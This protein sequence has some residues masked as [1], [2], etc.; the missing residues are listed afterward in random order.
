MKTSIAA[1]VLALAASASAQESVEAL[2]A[3]TVAPAPEATPV[4][5]E[6]APAPVVEQ[7]AAPAPEPIVAEA[8]PVEPALEPAATPAPAEEPALPSFG[9]V[10]YGTT[11]QRTTGAAQVVGKKQLERMKYD[12]PHAV[13]NGVAGIVTRGEDGVGLRPN[14]GMRGTNPDRSKKVTLLEDG[15]PF[16][17]AP[18]SA[19]A[20]YYFPLIGRMSQVRVLKGPAGLVYGP[21]TIGGAID[22]V[23]RAIPDKAS[24]GLDLGAGQFGFGKGH[25]WAGTTVDKLGVLVEGMHLRSDGFKQ[26]PNDANTGFIRNEWMAK[27]SYRVAPAHE[28]RLKLTYSD[29]VSNETYLGLTDADLQATPDLRYAATA[30]DQMRNHRTALVFTHVFTPREGLTLTTTIDRSAFDRTWRK[31]NGFRGASLF[32]VLRDPNDPRH[33]VYMN[34]LRG[35]GTSS[36][37]GETLLVGPNVRDFVL[38]GLQTRLHWDPFTGPVEHKVEAGLRLHYDAIERRHSE[39]GFILEAGE[40]IPEGSPT[41]VTAFNRAGTGA[42][43]AHVMDS[44]TWKKLTVTG[45][46]RVETMR[47]SYVDRIT[48][49]ETSRW[50]NAVLPSI[51]AFYGFTESFGVLGGVFQGFSP[52]APGSDAT[53]EPERSTNYELGARFTRKKAGIEIIGYY[54]DYANL[55]DICTLSSGCVDQDLD[56]QFDAGEARIYGVEATAREEFSLG[57]LRFPVSLAYTLTRANFSTA[58]DSDDPMYGKVAAGDELPYVPRHQ[59]NATVGIE[60]RRASLNVSGLYVSR[61]REISGSVPMDA[62]LATDAQFVVDASGSVKLREWLS[63]YTNVRNIADARYIVSRR[64]F[65]ARPN[66]PRW[67]QFGLKA[68]F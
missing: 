63:L 46:V 35:T 8:P 21:Q 54:N 50:A 14:I 12:D 19:P 29:E 39:D 52:P 48:N 9:A 44:A 37:P 6:A 45:G 3:A 34:L 58:F 43:A 26:L 62:T 57:R 67:V 16:A 24:A 36:S 23:T 22:F 2:P 15:V 20:A 13:L 47:S 40:L 65:G 17:P 18:Y 10:V 42:I 11:L 51:G 33:A 7:P 41:S 1:L 25:A 38:Q 32:D 30:L 64:P 60:H 66:A 31:V 61:M 56:R 49:T 55:T 59:L 53:V 68:D 27:G 5:A 28:L 4:A